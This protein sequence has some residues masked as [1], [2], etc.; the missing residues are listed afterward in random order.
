MLAAILS[1]LTL[2]FSW[3]I[4]YLLAVPVTFLVHSS[5]L[6][7]FPVVR[8]FKPIAG[9]VR[10]RGLQKFLFAV[11][12]VGLMLALS[13]LLDTEPA[14]LVLTGYFQSFMNFDLTQTLMSGLLSNLMLALGIFVIHQAILFTN[15]LFPR[16]HIILQG[17][18]HTRFH[19]IK[20]KSMELVTPDQITDFLLSLSRYVQIGLNLV[21]LVTGLTYTLSFFP[22]TQ[23]LASGIVE[24]LYGI[25]HG[26]GTTLLGF[27]PNLITLI[28]ILIATRYTLKLLRFFYEGVQNDRIKIFGL[29]KDLAEPTY[30]LLRFLV[31]AL[32]L[33]AAYPYL[34]GSNS[35]V[36]R[37]ITIFAGFLLSLGSTA[38]VTNIVSGVVL[39]YTRGLRI[40]DRV[41]IGTTTGDVVERTMLVTRIRT[42]KNV[43]VSIPNSMVL[44]NEIVNYSALTARDG[45]ILNT[46]VTIGYD[47]PWRKVYDLLI[48]SALATR[49]IQQ[50][51]KPFVLQTSL[52]DYYVSYELNAYTSEPK[53][54][55]LIYS[56]LHQNIQDH[57]NRADVEIMSP[58][59]TA[60][61]EGNKSTVVA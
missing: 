18:R 45:L 9:N 7:N 38:L 37:G 36:F 58:A 6:I 40:G 12:L 59:Y 30:Q 2:L 57:F 23:G 48:R 17:W 24:S 34:P 46:T 54:M 22:G 60:Y 26:F 52:D 33:V 29:H 53:R 11:F 39:T 28:F 14:L 19:V 25:F 32:A 15:E 4:A 16:L 42:I 61:R 21:L 47:V 49:D 44:N 51:P 8:V 20:F 31:L 50:T 35:P 13:I 1:F 5:G 41:K 3:T 43:V 56:E 10:V 55:A 27:L